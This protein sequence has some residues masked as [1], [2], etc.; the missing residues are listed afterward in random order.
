[1]LA[2]SKKILFFVFVV[3]TISMVIGDDASQIEAS[4]KHHRRHRHHHRHHKQRNSTTSTEI[5]TNSPME[6][7]I[8]Q[9]E[10]K[11]S[12]SELSTNQGIDFDTNH[13][14]S[15]TKHSDRVRQM[16]EAIDTH[17]IRPLMV[18][19]TISTTTETESMAQKNLS[20]I[21]T[22]TTNTTDQKVTIDDRIITTAPLNPCTTGYVWV[23]N[24]CIQTSSNNDA[25][26]DER[27]VFD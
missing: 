2:T 8:N 18:V 14:D 4:H 9:A 20:L 1:M 17:Q 3:A 15:T 16:D 11:T 10:L 27:I 25:I 23:Q 19:A 13:N 5:A 26:E 7:N 22:T 12:A 21:N 6:L 24:K